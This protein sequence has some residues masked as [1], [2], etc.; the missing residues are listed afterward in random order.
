MG[1]RG[2]L[3]SI[4][5]LAVAGLALGACDQERQPEVSVTPAASFTRVAFD[6]C[7]VCSCCRD[8]KPLA[9]PAAGVQDCGECLVRATLAAH[10]IGYAGPH[11]FELRRPQPGK[12]AKEHFVE[13]TLVPDKPVRLTLPAGVNA[14]G[15]TF[16][17]VPPEP[18]T[19]TM[20]SGSQS[21]SQKMVPGMRHVLAS[22][23]RQPLREV[24][25]SA[26]CEHRRRV[27]VRELWLSPPVIPSWPS[28]APVPAASWIDASALPSPTS[29]VDGLLEWG[30]SV[31]LQH[32]PYDK[33]VDVALAVLAAPAVVQALGIRAGIDD[34]EHE[35]HYD[36]QTVFLLQR[37]RDGDDSFWVEDGVVKVTLR[38]GFELERVDGRAFKAGLRR[39]RPRVSPDAATAVAWRHGLGDAA[40]PELAFFD[41]RA[42]Y[43]FGDVCQRKYVDA[44]NGRYFEGPILC[45]HG[46]CFSSGVP[47]R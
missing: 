27:S 12:D 22:A 13:L 8:G 29:S 47:R 40:Y 11:Q 20:S 36:R 26:K 4:V 3:R 38:D 25:I 41:G 24:D 23:D 21:V 31:L 37:L 34:F 46:G 44:R 30:P 18:C 32:T 17:F 10:T 5:T 16:G 2:A 33:P 35:K 6:S 7:N 28:A 14:F 15:L 43:G 45:S 19:L 1:S 39:P 42:V 9:F